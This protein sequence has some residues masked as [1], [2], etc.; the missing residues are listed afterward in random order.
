MNK[1]NF[2]VKMI[3]IFEM[4]FESYVEQ[5]MKNGECGEIENVVDGDED[6]SVVNIDVGKMIN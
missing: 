2:F 3:P 4:D 6:K 1:F 5:I